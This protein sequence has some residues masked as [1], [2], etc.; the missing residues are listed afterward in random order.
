M[1]LF[2]DTETSDLLKKDRPLDDPQ[3][4]WIV[5]VA[6]E[7]CDNQRPIDFFLRRVRADGRKI[8][9]GAAATHGITSHRAATFGASEIVVLGML[10]SFVADAQYVVGHGI[11][12]F[13]KPIIEGVLMRKGKDARLFSRSGLEFFDTMIAAAPF[14]KIE[15][16]PEREDGQYKWPSLDD[17]CQILLGEEPRQGE[18]NAWDDMRKCQRLFWRLVELRAFEVAA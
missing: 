10:S 1:Y 6:A 4:P 8:K 12:A 7:L 16:K 14:C 11:V 9:A 2:V 15:P 17:A 18:H 13:D 5:S 3:Q